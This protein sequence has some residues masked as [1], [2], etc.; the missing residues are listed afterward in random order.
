MLLLWSNLFW[1]TAE[2]T[3]HHGFLDVI[4]SYNGVLEESILKY[5]RYEHRD[6][7]CF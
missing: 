1:N 3:L 6:F 4:R 5:T 7:Y 2:K